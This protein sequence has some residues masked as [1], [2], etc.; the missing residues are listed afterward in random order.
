MPTRLQCPECGSQHRLAVQLTRHRL[1]NEA[2]NSGTF[3]VLL[4]RRS[5]GDCCHVWMDANKGEANSN[6]NY[7]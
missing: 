7:T 1:P 6:R 2:N 3:E 5:S 4:P